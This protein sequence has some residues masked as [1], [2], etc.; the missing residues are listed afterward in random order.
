MDGPALAR[1]TYTTARAAAPEIVEFGT[2]GSLDVGTI[3][4]LPTG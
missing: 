1:A 3:N 4:T 2:C